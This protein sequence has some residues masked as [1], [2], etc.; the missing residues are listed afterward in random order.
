MEIIQ[1]DYGRFDLMNPQRWST[2]IKI[3]FSNGHLLFGEFDNENLTDRFHDLTKKGPEHFADECLEIFHNTQGRWSSDEKE[4]AARMFFKEQ[5]SNRNNLYNF[6]IK[7]YLR[8]YP[9]ILELTI[10]RITKQLDELI[11]INKEV[12]EWNSLCILDLEEQPVKSATT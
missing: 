8:Q 2:I 3:E 7:E 5:Y 11:K 6:F 12:T 9:I 4:Q 10:K 1:N